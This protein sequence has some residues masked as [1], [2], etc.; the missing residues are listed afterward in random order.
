[1]KVDVA[2]I[3]G[4]PAGSTVASLLKIYNPSL[5]VA[6]IEKE[7]FPRDHVGESHLPV[8]SEVLAE[9]GVWD[10]VEAANF[11]IKIGGTYR[12]GRT[13][14][15]WD[16]E[17]LPG[18]QFVD[19]PRPAQYK[20][21]RRETAFQVDRAIY[22]KILLDHAESLGCQLIQPNK[23]TDV[24][25]D[26]DRCNGL[27]LENG[28][29][30]EARY[31]VDGSGEGGIV[32]KAM[33]VS[34]TAPTKLR[35]IAL[36][37]Y[38]TDAE[39]AV[40]IGNGGTR[41]QV[42][43]LGWGWIWFIPITDTRTSIGLVL[44]AETLKAKGKSPEDLYLEAVSTDPLVSE[45]IKSAKREGPVH[46][47]KDWNFLADR[48]YGENWFLSGDSCG[49]AD[50]ILSAG[51]T[52]AH[53]GARLLAYTI[54]E[55]DREELDSKWL[56]TQY[57][58][59]Q[60]FQIKQHMMFADY[61]YS[62]NG[63]FTDLQEYCRE[64]ADSAGLSLSADDAFR[65][66]ASGGFTTETPGL[67]RAYSYRLRALKL[68]VQHFSGDDAIFEVTEYNRLA[69]N[70]EGA[71]RTKLSVGQRGRII[72][73]DGFKRGNKRLHL[74][75]CFLALHHSLTKHNV[76]HDVLNLSIEIVKAMKFFN[77][78]YEAKAALVDALE[79]MVT[80]GWVTGSYD[81]SIPRFQYAVP[82]ESDSIHPN[83]DATTLRTVLV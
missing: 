26:N 74:A 55:L 1:M 80:E 14:E 38:W 34:I 83:R 12:W 24:L 28:D 23:V 29:T 8:I 30:V 62:S 58:E 77:S 72:A 43:S 13:D 39:W 60:R 10:K 68:I 51:M 73:L 36:W 53:T 82:K 63:R 22:D 47:T 25:V 42:L 9:M 27:V 32:R 4:G 78:E 79:S 46:G 71:E 16:F 18:K 67:A 48:L 20:G 41:I 52:L 69:L 19:E 59:T 44:P 76:I 11:P 21:Q 57:E 6:I 70:M 3:G 54:L 15:L 45:L 81:P 35:N 17:F 50:P 5:S 37:D 2:I 33:N 31:Y 56:K 40:T 61:W 75:G 49:F 66:L 65:W 64:I 7:V